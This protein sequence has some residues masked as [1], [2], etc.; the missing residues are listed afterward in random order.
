MSQAIILSS[1]NRKNK[2]DSNLSYISCKSQSFVDTTLITD[3][4]IFACFQFVLTKKLIDFNK[5]Y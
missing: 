5:L 3:H 1:E 4:S 2:L